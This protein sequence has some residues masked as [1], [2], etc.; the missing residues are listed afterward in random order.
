MMAWTKVILKPA[1]IALQV[2]RGTAVGTLF[3]VTILYCSGHKVIVAF[4]IYFEH[5]IGKISW[6]YLNSIKDNAKVLGL[7]QLEGLWYQFTEMEKREV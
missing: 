6:Y 1:H 5:R 2:A 3:T 7:E 4:W